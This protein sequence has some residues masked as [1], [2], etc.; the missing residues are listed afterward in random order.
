MIERVAK[1]YPGL[2]VLLVNER[3]SPSAAS[4]FLSSIGLRA[5]DVPLDEDGKVGDLYGVSG[6]PTSFFVRADGSLQGGY[7]GQM[8][9][10]ILTGHLGAIATN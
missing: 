3:D 4:S 1:R 2:V 8:N 10:A 9:E 7:I 5:V 6:L